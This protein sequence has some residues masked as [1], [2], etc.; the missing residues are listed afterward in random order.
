MKNA[1]IRLIHGL[2]VL[3]LLVI[4]FVFLIPLYWTFIMSIDST[5]FTEIPSPPRLLPKVLSLEN[6]TYAFKTVPLLRYVLNTAFVTFCCTVISVS[7]ALMGGYAFAKGRFFLKKFWFIVILAEMMLPF[8]AIMI[9]LYMQYVR[10]GLL[11]TYLPVILGYLKYPYGL[12]M[13]RQNIGALPDSL[14]ESCYIDGGSEWH[15]FL[16]VIVPLSKPVIAT[17]CI[18]QIISSWNSFLWP[19]IV[20]RNRSM[21][22]VSIGV[23]MFNATENV[24]LLGPRMA[25]AFISALP[26]VLLYLALQ[27]HIIE[28]IAISGM[29][30]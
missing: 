29:K 28:S 9:P 16:S 1:K 24:L 21:Y 17:M 30:D 13:S 2:T 6:Y 26:I 11:G 22:T 5:V 14:R 3:A 8:E 25:V 12:F 18:L 4:A 20:I 27:R 19:M 23:Q 7:T 10:W 15:T